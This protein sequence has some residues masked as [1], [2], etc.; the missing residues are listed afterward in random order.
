MWREHRSEAARRAEAD[1]RDR[2]IME[3]A[4]AAED[5]ERRRFLAMTDTEHLE[6]AYAAIGADRGDE[7]RRH[8]SAVTRDAGAEAERLLADLAR[9]ERAEQ[10]RAAAR[11]REAQAVAAAERRA[12]LAADIDR[13]LVQRGREIVSAR[14]V[15]TVL[16]VDYALCGRVFLESTMTPY[17][18]RLREAGFTRVEC[19]FRGRD[20][21]TLSI[22]PASP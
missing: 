21:F 17:M 6:A 19:S 7:A 12:A 20:R 13:D 16:R 14:A 1:A 5:A 22:T 9:R 3:A 18:R 2:R 15:S 8:L 4:R 10:S 11:G